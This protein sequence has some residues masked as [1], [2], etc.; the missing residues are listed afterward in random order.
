MNDG[1]LEGFAVLALSEPYCFWKEDKV[2][3]VPLGHAKWTKMIPTDR[4]EGRWPIRSMLWIR[5]DIEC[6]QVAMPSADMTAALLR[7]PD[8]SMLV[9]SVYVE[10]ANAH[11]LSETIKLLDELMRETRHRIGTRVDIVLAGDFNRHDLLWGGDDIS[12]HRQGE[13]DPIVDLMSDWSLQSLLP[14]GTKT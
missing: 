2:V 13:A 7:L 11:A 10:G 5:K 3:T 12:P 4:H 9:V 6:E 1:D 14:R 8:R